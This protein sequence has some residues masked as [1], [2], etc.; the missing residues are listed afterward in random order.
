MNQRPNLE[1]ELFSHLAK[2][3][4][5]PNMPGQIFS[6]HT[7]GQQQVINFDLCTL[8][9][10]CCHADAARIQMWLNDDLQDTVFS[11]FEQLSPTQEQLFDWNLEAFLQHFQRFRDSRTSHYTGTIP[12]PVSHNY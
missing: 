10:N 9:H 5:S 12:Y 1:S 11:N 8:Q 2:L 7:T 6:L 4:I 3:S